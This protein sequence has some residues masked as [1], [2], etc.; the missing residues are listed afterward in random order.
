MLW[1]GA[2]EP[3]T[4]TIRLKLDSESSAALHA[5]MQGDAGLDLAVL[6]IGTGR[7]PELDRAAEF[8]AA[9]GL[10]VPISIVTFTP[11]VDRSGSVLLARET[12]EHD[13]AP[14]DTT[15]R[16]K[17]NRGARIEW[18]LDMARDAGV[19]EVFDTALS[20]ASGLGLRIKPWP[21]SLTIVPP[22]TRGRT[23]VY[24]GPRTNG[25]VRFGFGFGEEAF[26][27]LYSADQADVRH[28]L[29]PNWGTPPRGRRW[30]G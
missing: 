24:L 21:K 11:F 20:M 7:A 9:K 8:L 2:L 6:L 30:T 19:Q 14:E 16:Q 13:I 22:F 1:L 23:L 15:P 3:E 28:Q 27:E 17:T 10:N 29:G 18:V 4:L 12:E 26:V 25:Q 5:G